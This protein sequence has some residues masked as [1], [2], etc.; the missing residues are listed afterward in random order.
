MGERLPAYFVGG[1]PFAGHGSAEALPDGGHRREWHCCV[2]AEGAR[3]RPLFVGVGS[4]GESEFGERGGEPVPGVGV[5]ADERG[6]ASGSLRANATELSEVQYA[7]AGRGG[8]A[9]LD[10][11]SVVV[12]VLAAV[13]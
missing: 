3:C 10:H 9:R 4:D 7:V 11:F 2:D 8:D 1:G 5:D 6:A 13:G 12:A